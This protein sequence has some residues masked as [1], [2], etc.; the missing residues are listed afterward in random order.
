LPTELTVE[1]HPLP[2]KGSDIINNLAAAN[3][4]IFCYNLLRSREL[5]NISSLALSTERAVLFTR[6]A[7]FQ[8][9]STATFVE[10]RSISDFMDA[11]VSAQM[12]TV[13]DFG[14]WQF[15]ANIRELFAGTSTSSQSR[16]PRGSGARQP[17]LKIPSTASELL[18]LRGRPFLEAAYLSVLG[19]PADP[20]G[21]TY[22]LSA[23]ER[24]MSKTVI[25]GALRSSAEGRAYGMNLPGMKLVMLTPIVGSGLPRANE[26]CE[27]TNLN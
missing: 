11:G 13:R 15:F 21:V 25:L 26:I 19:R 6:R 10:D 27:L 20:E 12:P 4:V 22:Y 8:C 1:V 24:G 2:Q 17:R 9:Y 7:P 18:D 14:E 5:E 23:L 3:L 16:P